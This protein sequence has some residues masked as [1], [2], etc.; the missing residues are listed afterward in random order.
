MR[1]IGSLLLG[2]RILEDRRTGGGFNYDVLVFKQSH[3][4]TC[5]DAPRCGKSSGLLVEMLSNSAPRSG[6]SKKIDDEGTHV[7][8]IV[9]SLR[10]QW[11]EGPKRGYRLRLWQA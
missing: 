9:G 4:Y 3:I 11:M 7:R 6:W 10:W 2:W 1:K 5:T 8:I